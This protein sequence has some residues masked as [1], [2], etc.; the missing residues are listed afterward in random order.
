MEEPAD[1]ERFLSRPPFFYPPPGFTFLVLFFPWSALKSRSQ[2]WLLGRGEKKSKC[3]FRIHTIRCS[4]SLAK[5]GS[6]TFPSG[7]SFPHTAPP[8]P[9]LLSPR[10]ANHAF[11]WVFSPVDPCVFPLTLSRCR[12]FVHLSTSWLE[13]KLFYCR[14]GL[15][16]IWCPHSMAPEGLTEAQWNH[17]CGSIRRSP[18]PN[19]V[20]LDAEFHWD[21]A[22]LATEEMETCGLK[23][24]AGFRRGPHLCCMCPYRSQKRGLTPVLGPSWRGGRWSERTASNSYLLYTSCCSRTVLR[25]L[26]IRVWS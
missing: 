15:V 11:L 9:F 6:H 23:P 10:G 22:W 7:M 13:C 1:K 4:I 26:Q 5:G 8:L 17:C 2:S 16:L 3:S 18:P 21:A 25:R 19:C 24:R 12:L 14:E 20:C